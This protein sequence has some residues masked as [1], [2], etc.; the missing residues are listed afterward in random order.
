MEGQ[1]SGRGE[2]RGCHKRTCSSFPKIRLPQNQTF[3]HY[4]LLVSGSSKLELLQHVILNFSSVQIQLMQQPM[5]SLLPDSWM[6]E[7]WQQVS[8]AVPLASLGLAS[9]LLE[10]LPV[11]HLVCVLCTRSSLTSTWY[12]CSLLQLI[13]IKL[14]L[15]H[16]VAA[17]IRKIVENPSVER[18]VFPL[19]S[20]Y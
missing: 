9:R 19:V 13:I 1:E 15:V 4:R 11:Q 17:N 6:A 12:L 18:L 16:P 8:Y 3:L 7:T 5:T 2:Q 20:C 10:Q 14:P